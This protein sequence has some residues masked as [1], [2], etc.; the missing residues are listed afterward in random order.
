MNHYA[1]YVLPCYLFAFCLLLFQMMI[2][3]RSFHRF[4]KCLRSQILK[5]QESG[6][7]E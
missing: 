5:I 2:A 1:L 6:K 4:V 7:T 3:V